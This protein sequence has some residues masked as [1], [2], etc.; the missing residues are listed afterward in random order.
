MDFPGRLDNDNCLAAAAKN[1]PQTNK[2]N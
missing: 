2:E 1:N